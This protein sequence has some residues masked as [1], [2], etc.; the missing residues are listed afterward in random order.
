MLLF[1]STTPPLP[2]SA[3]ASS[4][5]HNTS[6]MS[7]SLS[8]IKTRSTE[9]SNEEEEASAQSRLEKVLR[10][11]LKNFFRCSKKN[12]LH[13]RI[14]SG[15]V[16]SK[17]SFPSG[18]NIL[19]WLLSFKNILQTFGLEKLTTLTTS[20]LSGMKALI[21]S[22]VLMFVVLSVQMLYTFFSDFDNLH[23]LDSV[24]FHCLLSCSLLSSTNPLMK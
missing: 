19:P 14:S 1:S 22:Y 24:F 9:L 23:T 13:D 3:S 11:L 12:I 17:K 18:K 4:T 6:S 20:I 5:S 15:K 16:V 2:S 8:T 10:V 21:E 7:S